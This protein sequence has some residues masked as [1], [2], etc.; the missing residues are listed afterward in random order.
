MDGLVIGEPFLAEKGRVNQKNI[1]ANN[2]R[3]NMIGL[4]ELTGDP[5]MYVTIL[6]ILVE[7]F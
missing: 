2:R 6:A 4:T 5:V 1:F 3:I 7:I